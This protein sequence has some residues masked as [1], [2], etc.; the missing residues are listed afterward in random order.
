M[1]KVNN[2]RISSS[3]ATKGKS[4]TSAKAAAVLA[5]LDEMSVSLADEIS[6]YG[7]DDA[8][9]DLSVKEETKKAGSPATKRLEKMAESK[10]VVYVDDDGSYGVESE[11]DSTVYEEISYGLARVNNEVKL[12]KK[13]EKVVGVQR[14]LFAANLAEKHGG[15]FKTE[16]NEKMGIKSEKERQRQISSTPLLPGLMEED[17]SEDLADLHKIGSCS[18]DDSDASS[19][20]FSIEEV[21]E[22]EEIT[23]RTPVLAPLVRPPAPLVQR[24]SSSKAK[25]YDHSIDKYV[26]SLSMD[27]SVFDDSS[28]MDMQMSR[29]PKIKNN[30]K[31]LVGKKGGFDKTSTAARKNEGSSLFPPDLLPT[32]DKGTAQTKPMKSE[33]S[34]ASTVTTEKTDNT[35]GSWGLFSR[36]APKSSDNEAKAASTSKSDNTRRGLGLCSRAAPKADKVKHD[37][38]SEGSRFDPPSHLS[39]DI[40]SATSSKQSKKRNKVSSSSSRVSSALSLDDETEDIIRAAIIL[41]NEDS[42]RS[43]KRTA[44]CGFSLVCLAAAATVGTLVYTNQIPGFIREPLSKLGVEVTASSPT[45]EN[46]TDVEPR[47]VV[48]TAWYADFDLYKCVQD[49]DDT[50]ESI[51]CGG[52]M[53]SWEKGFVT[54]EECW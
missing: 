9:F 46:D 43:R 6:H 44:L 26:H 21:E 3:G 54:L 15:P 32:V 29:T 7:D 14:E 20:G 39:L 52:K 49:C 4:A 22:E 41:R 19:D 40:E 51:T 33:S 30:K 53:A 45:A 11:D 12:N 10:A 27:D 5:R 35:R 47:G 37:E 18:F 36:A 2:G 25:K 38:R 8:T 16:L 23:E 48:G 1:T 42:K 28:I 17:K 50:N 34:R 31:V 24:S 13:D